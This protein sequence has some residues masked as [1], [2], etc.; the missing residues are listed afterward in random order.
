MDNK[1]L[2]KIE[3]SL[4]SS[5]TASTKEVENK[6]EI[7][8]KAIKKLK[9]AQRPKGKKKRKY[10]H[11]SKEERDKM[12]V[13]GRK[14]NFGPWTEKEHK[15][16]LEAIE[17]Y[18]NLWKKVEAYVGTRTTAQIR[19]H[20][21]KYFQGL[22]I[23]TLN[24][25]KEK[26]QLNN[27]VFIVIKEYRNYSKC[28]D[29]RVAPK[30]SNNT[31]PKDLES[32]KQTEESKCSDVIQTEYMPSVEGEYASI[33]DYT[34][35]VQESQ[36]KYSQE[37]SVDQQDHQSHIFST[38]NYYGV[39]KPCLNEPIFF[40]EYNGSQLPYAFCANKRKRT[41]SILGGCNDDQM[42]NLPIENIG[43]QIELGEEPDFDMDFT[44]PTSIL[45]AIN[46]DI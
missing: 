2:L 36:R 15:I 17:K 16:F 12:Q 33:P 10:S 19:S 46:Y 23:K 38:S 25:L 6:V 18:G 30:P 24:E 41:Q 9:D 44:P 27:H 4:R 45:P 13:S 22:R 3:R 29:A 8:K 7:S 21:Q 39:D 26:N 11:N 34:N 5:T 14:I 1:V 42:M 20:S 35:I 31:E 28:V 40:G 43:N 37:N 32:Q